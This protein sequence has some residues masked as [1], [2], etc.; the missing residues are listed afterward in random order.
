MELT[1][2]LRLASASPRRSDLLTALGLTFSVHPLDID[3]IVPDGLPNAEAAEY[4]AKLKAAAADHLLHAGAGQRATVLTAD[5][6]VLLGEELL[7]KPRDLDE[8]RDVLRRLCGATHTV[9][10]GFCLRWLDDAGTEGVMSESVRTEVTLAGA[11]EAE[12]DYYVARQPPL[13]RAGSYGIQDWIGWAKLVRLEGSYSN[14][15]GLPTARVYNA[16]VDNG[17]LR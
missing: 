16:L 9:V 8:A 6:V 3:E 13:D 7:G 2:P 4:L 12:I 11:T 5:S 1:Q 14:V 10:T 17:L 15:M